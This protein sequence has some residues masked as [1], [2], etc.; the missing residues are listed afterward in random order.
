MLSSPVTKITLLLLRKPRLEAVA[1]SWRHN[2]PCSWTLPTTDF[3]G[4]LLQFFFTSHMEGSQTEARRTWPLPSTGHFHQST[5]VMDTSSWNFVHAGWQ[6]QLL[7][8][9]WCL[10]Q[11][12]GVLSWATIFTSPSTLVWHQ[13][14]RV[15][16]KEGVRSNPENSFCPPV[17]H[18][19]RLR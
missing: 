1:F 14:Q 5:S 19:P 10:L 3:R 4:F 16:R 15:A 6:G 11:T 17:V 12:L 18:H 13:P 2:Q 9:W 8:G 7:W